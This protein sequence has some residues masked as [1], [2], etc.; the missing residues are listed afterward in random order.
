MRSLVL[1]EGGGGLTSKGSW[2]EGNT[3]FS[4]RVFFLFI[5]ERGVGPLTPLTADGD[6]WQYISVGFMSPNARVSLDRKL[7]SGHG[8][9]HVILSHHSMQHQV[10]K[11]TKFTA[12][13]KS[14]NEMFLK[15][16]TLFPRLISQPRGS[17]C[18][19]IRM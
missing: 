13:S 4:F 10:L 17:T 2:L 14:S 15:S 3:F 16:T 6:L 19:W 18:Y 5:S 12:R 11:L 8:S 9:T 1:G 7:S